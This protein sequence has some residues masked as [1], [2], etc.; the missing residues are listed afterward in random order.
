[1]IDAA[2]A[3]N[4]KRPYQP[5]HWRAI[6]TTVGTTPDGIPGKL[7]AEAVARWQAGHD[8]AVDGKAGPATIAAMGLDYVP[9]LD[10]SH[11]EGAIDWR[12]VAADPAGYRGVWIKVTQDTDFEDPRAHYN[13]WEAA[14]AGLRVGY[15][16]YADTKGD[17][18]RGD[19]LA[20]VDYF[21]EAIQGLPPS[22]LPP[23]LDIE[24]DMPLATAADTAWCEVWMANVRGYQRGVGGLAPMVYT[25]ARIVEAELLA[26][27]GLGAYALWA[28]RYNTITNPPR[29]PTG[30]DWWS[31]WQYTDEGKVDGISSN[32]D[33]NRADPT[34]WASLAP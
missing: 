29:V 15:F 28:P 18:G 24:G 1:M 17:T 22:T 4:A 7:T 21:L 16:H 23:V 25:S 19:P 33:R 26:D 6:Q 20:Q 34:W 8:L 5:P 11:H 2:I 14:S 9:L 30:W 27:H 32:V 31:V 13:A 12:A 10:V 3:Y